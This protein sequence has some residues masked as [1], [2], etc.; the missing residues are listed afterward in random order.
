MVQEYELH[1]C[2][3]RLQP[4]NMNS[5]DVP[6]TEFMSNI[7]NYYYNVMPLRFKNIDT[8]Y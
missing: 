6:K 4:N 1:G 8:T 7:C 2:L 5:L 3:F